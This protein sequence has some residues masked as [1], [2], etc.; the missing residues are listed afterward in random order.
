MKASLQHRLVWTLLGFTLFAWLASAGVTYVYVNRV[1]Q[2]QVD[3]Q[4]SQYASLVAYITGVFARQLEEGAPLYESWSGHD[5]GQAYLEPIV[6]DGLG[7]DGFT[8]AVNIWEDGH[9]IAVLEGSPRFGPP[10]EPGIVDAEMPDGSGHWRILSRYSEEDAVWIRVGIERGAAR[11]DLLQTLGR[12]LLPLLIV[13][14]LTIV[15]LYLGV[16]RG[17][18][19]LRDL[20]EQ[21]SRRKPG[22]LDPVDTAA[23]PAEV[24]GVVDALNDLLRRLAEA[25]ESEQRFTAN[26]AHELLTPLAAIKT[27][28]QL[29]ER[30]LRG[31]AGAE[32]LARI[33]SR[34]DR[35][36]H[37][38]EQL[39]TLARLD[40]ERPQVREP[41]ALRPLLETALADGGHLAAQRDLR[42]SLEDGP[43][44]TIPGSE[45]AIAILLRNLVN[46]AFRYATL[47]SVVRLALSQDD[48]EVRLTI[49]NDC[50]PLTEAEF[51]QLG[52]RFYRVPGSE[53]MGSGLG[54]SIV[55]RIAELHEATIETGPGERG[56]GFRAAVRFIQR[57]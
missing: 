30:Q 27:E 20:A 40:P 6:I 35:A 31:V 36:S 3:S 37:S 17:L 15:V 25:L 50:E 9:L 13:L 46:N 33:A 10:A 24:A 29:C 21:I 54:L 12:S 23:V 52:R 39:L 16:T 26:A 11:R 32:K 47:G 49:D 7:A 45:E 2:Q 43:D 53:G 41:V 55:N 38:V 5:Y 1:L 22:L 42:V 18:R 8:P 19:P 51:A 14:P 48:G 56:R 4:L 57:A 28:V 44:C 34:V